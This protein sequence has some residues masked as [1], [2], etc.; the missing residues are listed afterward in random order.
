MKRILL[1]FLAFSIISLPTFAKER[2][3][4]VIG[5]SSYKVQPLSNPV[6][7]ARDMANMLGKLG[8]T[9]TLKVNADQ[10]TMESAIEA[11]GEKLNKNT[12]GLFYFSGH[13]A[14]YE[15][16]NFLI[17]VNS[18]HKISAAAHLR[19]KAVP[20]GYVLGTM[21][22]NAL[23]IVILD[24]C[25]SN[26]F[27]G[28]SK[29]LG[30]GLASM[31]SA[32]GT[33]IAYATAPGTVAWDG[34]AGERNSPYT[35]HLLQFMKKPNLSI[36]SLLKKVRNAVIQETR[37][38]STVQEPWYEASISDDF[39]FIKDFQILT[40]PAIQSET[41]TYHSSY[42]Y[43]DNGNGTVTDSRSGLIWLKN[44][45]CFGYQDWGTA[46]RSATNLASGQC[47]L[48]DGSRRGMW[49]LPTK[50]EWQAMI[51]KKYVDR[52]N[53]NQPA[54]SNAAGTGK[55]KEGDAFSGVQTHNYWSSTTFAPTTALAWFVYFSNG[56]VYNTNKTNMRY[57]WPVR[58][59]Q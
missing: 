45:N 43:T 40:T 51:D 48:R 46:R 7:D 10:V 13:G 34:R 52:Q 23:N 6:N 3:A 28:F 1:I 20:A 30:Q 16:E 9:V 11:F 39:Y 42:R 35:K 24:A 31:G 18:T 19:Y 33:L 21:Q 44:A 57:V 37:H 5:N 17:P 14:Q 53:Y 47:G 50:E 36:E 49:R 25:R 56:Y 26:P 22:D 29:S 15:G 59:R 58:G 12:V 32:T 2:V 54:L 55:W 27:K 8:F 4:L 41:S 38:N